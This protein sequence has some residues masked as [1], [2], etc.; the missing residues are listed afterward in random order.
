MTGQVILHYSILEKIGEGGMGVVYKAEDTTL[1]RT[2]AL[3]FLPPQVSASE[4]DKARF[5]QEAQAAAALNHP[6]ICTIYGIET[7]G[8]QTFIAMEFIDGKTLREVM[9]ANH[10]SGLPHARAIDIGIQIADG[11]AVAHEKGIV[12]RDIKPENIMVRKDGIVQIMDFGLAKL[13]ASRAS[14]LT[15]EGSTIGTAGYMSPEQVQG[16]DIDHRSDIFSVGVLLY[17]LFAGELPFRGVHE[18]A[19]LYEI[20]NVDPPP[21]SV[22]K[23]SI[24][25]ELDR[26]VLECLQKEPDERYQAVKDVSKDLKRF[27]RESSRARV[28]RTFTAQRPAVQTASRP[29][30]AAEAKAG[31]TPVRWIRL[32]IAFA[33]GAALVAA[34]WQPW[35]PGVRVIPRVPMRFTMKLRDSIA[36]PIGGADIAISPDGKF[37][38]FITLRGTVAMIMLRPMDR[39]T[40]E[41]VSGSEDATNTQLYQSFSPDGQWI[42]FTPGNMLKKA[43]VFGGSAVTVASLAA[44]PRGLWWGADHRI[45]FGYINSPIYCVAE[46]GGTPEPVTQLDSAGGEISHRFP[47]LLPDGKSVLYTVKFNNIT[48]FDDAAIAVRD[49]KTGRQTMLIRGGSFARYVPTGHIVYGRGN[50]IYAA[51]FDPVKLA[52][53]GP[54]RQLFRGGWMSPFS[55]EVNLDFSNDGTLLY[56]PLGSESYAIGSVKWIDKHGKI[57][58]LLDTANSYFTSALSPDG[59]KLALHVQAANDDIWVYHFGRH[60]LTRLT[61]G[62]GNSGFPVWTP[63]GRGIIYAAER[64]RSYNIF[65]RSWDGS[66]NEDL[67]S[68]SSRQQFPSSITPDGRTLALV[69]D[70]DLFLLSLDGSRKLTPFIQSDAEKTSPVFSPDGK[71]IAYQTNESGRFEIV[72]TSYPSRNGK[73]QIS[74]SGGTTPLWD[75]S[76]RELY[77]VQGST[78]CDVTI[79]A[80][81]TFDYSAPRRLFDLPA[82]GAGLTDIAR[83]GSRFVM[84]TIPYEELTTSEITLVTDWFEELKN[85]FNSK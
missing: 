4:T 84:Q 11:L 40:Y 18:T 66:G 35:V 71:Y 6:N 28:S 27:K 42:S 76:G 22:V 41:P 24:D 15:K 79:S 39:E 65:R 1:K 81:E 44:Q 17:E 70:H 78:V 73:W 59:Q 5:L 14:R 30:A 36:I 8:D 53:T 74:S 50:F 29:S 77:F 21:M 63:D 46:D 19:L 16:Q 52:I 10:G 25:P 2:V 61:F 68:V 58:S 26:I 33:A 43:S 32:V 9:D 69:Q 75:P 31:R 3:K 49:G 20:V 13:R 51:P 57:S 37:V 47:Q 82:N 54:P 23:P 67:L 34:L 12:H 60:A 72:V 38:S 85:T 56:V 48:T 45:Y 64:G 7:A 55:G 83:D 62:G 80:G